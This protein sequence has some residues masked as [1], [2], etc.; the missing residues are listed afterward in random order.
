MDTLNDNLNFESII[1]SQFFTIIE[2]VK[3]YTTKGPFLFLNYQKKDYFM[4]YLKTLIFESESF[5]DM[6]EFLI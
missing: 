4:D 5:K 3:E 6:E 1:F 2:F